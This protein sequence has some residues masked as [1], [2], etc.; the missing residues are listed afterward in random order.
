MCW[1]RTGRAAIAGAADRGH[2]H[3]ERARLGEASAAMLQQTLADLNTADRNSF[4]TGSAGGRCQGRSA[5]VPVP[6]GPQAGHPVHRQRPVQGADQREAAPAQDRGRASALVTSALP[7]QPSWVTVIKERRQG[8]QAGG[9]GPRSAGKTGSSPG[10]A[11][12]SRKPIPSHAGKRRDR[13]ESPAI[14]AARRP[15]K[16][17]I[18]RLVRH[19]AVRIF[20]MPLVAGRA[21]VRTRRCRWSS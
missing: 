2:G 21:D 20:R 14:R 17:R 4:A 11:Q 19:P 16:R 3:P 10:A 1:R 9:D 8:R 5:P 6:Q 15:M 12:R 18:S 13:R 7:P